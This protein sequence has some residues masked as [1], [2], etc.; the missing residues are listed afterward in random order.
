MEE[1]AQA[2][3]RLERQI[4]NLAQGLGSGMFREYKQCTA[5]HWIRTILEER[6]S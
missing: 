5:S 3:K 2:R 1:I 6:G 4:H